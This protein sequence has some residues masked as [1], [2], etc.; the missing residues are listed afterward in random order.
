MFLSHSHEDKEFARK[1]AK[2]LTARG[3]RVWIDEAEIRIGDSL[4]EKIR[5][6]IDAVEF[7]AAVLSPVSV[8]APWV[9][10][11]LDVAMNQEIE[12]RRV[13]VLPLMYRHC[14]PPGFLKGKLW[15]DFT[16]EDYYPESLKKLVATLMQAISPSVRNTSVVSGP[17]M[18]QHNRAA[19]WRSIYHAL[20]DNTIAEA[21]AHEV[22]ARSRDV[23]HALERLPAQ[24][25]ADFQEAGRLSEVQMEEMLGIATACVEDFFRELG[26][27]SP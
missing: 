25:I 4:I 22:A 6:G 26:P 9:L 11:E 1:L 3:A 10:R 2:D 17:I 18:G 5:E 20:D 23:T 19:P 13:K 21:V 14:E 27:K 16:A 8:K 24:L 12:G 7:V 15:A